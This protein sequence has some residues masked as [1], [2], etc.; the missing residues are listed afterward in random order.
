VGIVC[1]FPGFA[2]II[3][4]DFSISLESSQVLR[5]HYSAN[6]AIWEINDNFGGYDLIFDDVIDFG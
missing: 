4:I 6:G 1:Y 3:I 2:I 5:G